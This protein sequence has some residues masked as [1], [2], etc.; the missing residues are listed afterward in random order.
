M[1]EVYREGTSHV[2]RNVTCERKMVSVYGFEH[3]L[4]EGWFLDE[5]DVYPEPKQELEPEPDLKTKIT[6]LETKNKSGSVKS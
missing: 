5:K 4:N 2:V 1:I 3:L 6:I